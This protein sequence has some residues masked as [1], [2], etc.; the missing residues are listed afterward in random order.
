MSKHCVFFKFFFALFYFL[1]VLRKVFLQ[2]LI[3]KLLYRKE[4]G[5]GFNLTV[6]VVIGQH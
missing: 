3:A 1:N 4:A 5:N 2:F 6:M